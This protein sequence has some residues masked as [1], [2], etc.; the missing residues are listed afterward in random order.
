MNT[1]REHIVM[2]SPEKIKNISPLLISQPNYIYRVDSGKIHICGIRKINGEKTGS[3]IYIATISAGS[4]FFSLPMDEEMF[5]I[6]TGTQNA[7]YS[8]ITQ[9]DL[10]KQYFNKKTEEERKE[11]LQSY[12]SAFSEWTTHLKY[13]EDINKILADDDMLEQVKTHILLYSE[14][15]SEYLHKKIILNISAENNRLLKKAELSNN[16]FAAILKKIGSILEKKNSNEI[17]TFAENQECLFAAARYTAL[18]MNIKLHYPENKQYR[19]ENNGIEEIAKD[20]NIR[21]REIILDTDWQKKIH[22][23]VLGFFSEEKYSPDVDKRFSDNM[24]PVA[25]I[26]LKNIYVMYNPATGTTSHLSNENIDKIIPTAYQFYRSFPDKKLSLKDILFFCIQDGCGRDILNYSL[27]GI[28]TALI[29]LIIPEMTRIFTDTVIPEA[30]KN[31]MVQLSILMLLCTSSTCLF[32]LTKNIAMIRLQTKTSLS[33]Q[34]A[35]MDRVMKMPAPF[36]RKYSSGD[37]AERTMGIT[38]IYEIVSGSALN[39]I[40]G[41]IFSSVYLIQMFRYNKTLALWGIIFVG[42]VVLITAGFMLLQYKYEKSVMNIQGK[43]MGRLLQFMIGIDK[44]NTTA[45]EQRAFSVWAKD[46]IRQKIMS[47]KSGTVNNIISTFLVVFPVITSMLFYLIYMGNINKNAGNIISTGSFLAF[48]SAYTT[49]QSSFLNITCSAISSIG[50]IPLYK[51]IKPI[52][53]TDIETQ[54]KKPIAPKLKG[55]IEVTGVSFRYSPDGPEILQNVSLTVRQGEFAAIVGP[56]GSGKS[57][58]LRLLLGFEKPESG[59]IYYD[60]QDIDSFDISSIRRQMGVVLQNGSLMQGS[61]YKNIIGSS[62]LTVDDAWQAAEAVGLADDIR[63]MPMGM[64][65]L[66]PV[67][68]GTISGGQRQRLIIA[69]AIVRNPSILLFDE[70]TSALDNRTQA[71]VTESLDNL[72][73]TRIV[74]AHRLSTIIHA[75]TIYVM[76]NGKIVESGSYEQLMD[77]KSTFYKLAIRQQV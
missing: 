27:F 33:L 31:M 17:V 72:N 26:P 15:T 25:L 37:M 28:I 74:I 75:D 68:G 1:L 11:I 39:S 8:F 23:P 7:T 12:K 61:I 65:T 16:E 69:R 63:E 43:I 34:S 52:L 56:S 47:F 59:S 73:V 54:S 24:Q 49:F 4:Y 50:I 6:A 55:N 20:N 18:S 36:F 58:L 10:E 64:H 41:F 29:G 44:I 2:S 48:I 67:G 76:E 19:I 14:K 77:K 13:N 62:S 3:R 71:M 21:I 42:F 60:N 70:A 51:R 57:T 38:D 40:M 46:F 45:S 9:Q 22:G 30:A 32:E 53:E 35:V 66:I 5:F